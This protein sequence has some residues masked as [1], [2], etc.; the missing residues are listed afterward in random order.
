MGFT[1]FGFKGS[2]APPTNFLPGVLNI[3]VRPTV[4]GSALTVE[5]H[6]LAWSGDPIWK[7]PGVSA[8][9]VFAARAKVFLR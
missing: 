8:A 3:G 4:D 5:V 9:R 1:A 2:V 6:L 7:N